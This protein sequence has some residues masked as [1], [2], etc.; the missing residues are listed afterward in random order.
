MSLEASIAAVGFLVIMI[1][2]GEVTNTM[3]S[4]VCGKATTVGAGDATMADKIYQIKNPRAGE[5]NMNLLI[6]AVVA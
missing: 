1:W 6:S 5:L 4:D 2:N 3:V